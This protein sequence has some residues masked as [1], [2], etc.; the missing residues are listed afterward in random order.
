M[1]FKLIYTCCDIRVHIIKSKIIVVFSIFF[2]WHSIFSSYLPSQILN[3]FEWNLRLN[4]F[5]SHTILN[6]HYKP[7]T[8]FY[9]QYSLSSAL[10]K[11][12][13]EIIIQ[14]S[15]TS[16]NFERYINNVRTI[17]NQAIFN[18]HRITQ[19]HRNTMNIHNIIF[20]WNLN[21]S[22]FPNIQYMYFELKELA[23][24]V[25]VSGSVYSTICPLHFQS[26]LSGNEGICTLNTA[27]PCNIKR[28]IKAPLHTIVYQVQILNTINFCQE[29]LLYSHG[30]YSFAYVKVSKLI[31]K[32][33]CFCLRIY[34]IMH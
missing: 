17:Y 28:K 5:K 20:L 9:I 4:N 23:L 16:F 7:W 10:G 2:L 26:G 25:S 8:Y 24:T 30:I 32:S 21:F 22:H 1:D 19:L 31:L 34:D 14:H 6:F 27:T 12:W 15:K 3:A 11:I 29:Y 33:T 18:E 13:R